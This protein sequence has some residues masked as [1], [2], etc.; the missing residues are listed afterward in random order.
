[1]EERVAR[2]EDAQERMVE[3]DELLDELDELSERVEEVDEEVENLRAMSLYASG[4]LKKMG[5]KMDDMA[6]MEADLAEV[7]PELDT[8]IEEKLNRKMA[9]STTGKVGRMP[10]MDTLA[11]SLQMTPYQHEKSQEV[12][13]QAK[14]DAFNIVNTPRPDGTTLMGDLTE[15][16]MSSDNPRQDG[17]KVMMKVLYENVPGKDQTYFQ[18]LKELQT[19]T[20]NQFTELLTEEQMMK[21]GGMDVNV[22]GVQ[23]GYSPLADY[24]R[25]YMARQGE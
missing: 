16:M 22:F 18:A 24:L 17:M 12:L 25:D 19:G 14:Y 4:K 21:Y 1:M 11:E 3:A 9:D 7:F 13:N 20:Q 23:T 8:M 6:S 5:V 2:L 10:T 15:A